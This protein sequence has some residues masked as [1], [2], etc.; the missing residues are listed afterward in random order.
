MHEAPRTR[1]VADFHPCYPLTQVF[2]HHREGNKAFDAQ[3]VC[4]RLC[5]TYSADLENTRAELVS[6]IKIQ[7]NTALGNEWGQLFFS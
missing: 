5:K 6:T 3:E 7:H 2:L 4:R 1:D